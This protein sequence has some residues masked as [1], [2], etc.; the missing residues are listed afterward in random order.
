M[1]AADVKD[2]E[3][4]F[5]AGEF[6][7]SF[8]L[9]RI[10]TKDAKNGRAQYLMGLFYFYGIFVSPDKDI[11]LEYMDKAQAAGEGL[12]E[13]YLI[14]SRSG[15]VEK[16]T[17]RRWMKRIR[18]KDEGDPFAMHQIGKS[19]E[20]GLA[21]EVDL[22]KALGWYEKAAAAGL[23]MAMTDGGEILSR[24]N[25]AGKDFKKAYLLFLEAAAKGYHQAEALL[26]DAYYCGR[27]VAADESKAL[28]CFQRAVDHGNSEA[29]DA[30]G[31]LYVLGSGVEQDAAKA[32]SYFQLGAERGNPACY[33]KW[34]D[35]YFYGRGTAIDYK[36]AMEL[37]EKSW[38][39]GYVRA[40]SAIGM[41]HLMGTAGEKDA[42]KGFA[43]LLK[44]A[45]GGDIDGMTYLG[46]CYMDGLGTKADKAKAKTYL[47]LAA[48]QGQVEAVS[49]LG[50]IALSEKREIEAVNH[51]KTAA[52]YGYTRAENLL[53]IC[54]AQ[55][56][57][58]ERNLR[59][60]EEWFR[61]S[62]TA[63]NP[64]ARRLMKEYLGM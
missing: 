39:L 32:I 47:T 8:A 24:R 40:A 62:E 5:L 54:Y 27:G 16:E 29:C 64:D 59:L 61:K 13:F 1:L 37:Y 2:V 12:A 35:C 41:L 60:A 19:Y 26:A 11:S 22:E 14:G 33:F 20:R 7:K 56:I 36:K 9:L 18:A 3:K 53:A 25:F 28:V 34:A 44:A 17:W 52:A 43:W 46:K 10:L 63:G 49:M 38:E 58:V 45:D 21:T 30:L 6:A 48:K 23:V 55:G 50:E 15:G 31:T 57:G 51:F 4:L 42:K